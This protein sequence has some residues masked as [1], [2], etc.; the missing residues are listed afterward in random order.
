MSTCQE[1]LQ[2]QRQV[3][4]YLSQA[5]TDRIN[6]G[7]QILGARG[8]SIF[9]SSG[10][11]GSHFSFGP[12][13]GGRE[14]GRVLNEISCQVH[15]VEYMPMPCD[16][17]SQNQHLVIEFLMFQFQFPVFPTASPYVT[18]VGGE[19]R[20]RCGHALRIVVVFGCKESVC[21]CAHSLRW[22]VLLC[23][24]RPGGF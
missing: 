11:G 22:A 20:G 13:D 9:G 6:H 19:V 2:Q 23:A 1:F 8:V 7:F 5:Q 18:S 24:H 4:M 12:F 10:D 14:I 16:R 17:I 15:T 21:Q 3:C